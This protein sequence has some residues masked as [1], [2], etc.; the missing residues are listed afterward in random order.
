MNAST[1]LGPEHGDTEYPF[2]QRDFDTIATMVHA[3]SGICLSRSK[4]MLVYSRL[5]KRLRALRLSNFAEYVEFIRTDADERTRSIEALTTNHTRFFR[6]KHHFDHFES[7][8]RPA[9][10]KRLEGG[11]RVRLWSSASSSGEEPYSLAMVM[12]GSDSAKANA[13]LNKDIALLATDLASHA[14][15]T[16]EAGSYPAAAADDIPT[17]YHRLWLKTD[18]DGVSMA[19]GLKKLVRF[20]RLNLLNPWPIKGQF[21]AIFCRNVMI[22]F[23]E[24]TK[25]TLIKRLTDQLVVGGFLYIGHSERIIGEATDKLIASGQTIYRKARS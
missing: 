9:L 16:G 3:H 7:E 15:E 24:P 14:L 19:P 17:Q 1:L 23:D 20:R 22:Y 6:E 12:L 10:V 21:D 25:A 18:R 11:G 5:A 8:V 2:E 13:L 4:A